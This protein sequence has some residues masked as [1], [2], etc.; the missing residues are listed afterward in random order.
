MCHFDSPKSAKEIPKIIKELKEL[1]ENDMVIESYIVNG[2][3]LAKWLRTRWTRKEIYKQVEILNINIGKPIDLGYV[4]KSIRSLVVVN[5]RKM[6]WKRRDY[7]VQYS[8]RKVS[9]PSSTMSKANG[10]A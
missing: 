10:S 8:G 7:C 6:R 9:A 3:R 1:A 2:T 5:A 4:N